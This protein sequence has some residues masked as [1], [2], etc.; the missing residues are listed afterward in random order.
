[1]IIILKTSLNRFLLKY[2]FEFYFII[3]IN[4]MYFQKI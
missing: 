4:L 2:L 3:T 1:M